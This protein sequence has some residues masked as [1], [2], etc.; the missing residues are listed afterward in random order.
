MEVLTNM[1]SIRQA[2]DMTQADLATQLGITPSAVTQ[3][4]TGRRYPKMELA[5]HA[6]CILGCGLDDL[7]PLARQYRSSA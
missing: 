3:W 4:E 5:I 6:A 7:F 1:R 2:A